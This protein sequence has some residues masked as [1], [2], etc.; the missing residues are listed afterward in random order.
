MNEIDI[1][2][3]A[4]NNEKTIKQSLQKI[5]SYAPPR[6]LIVIDGVSKDRTLEI[7]T[8]MGA[9][10]HSDKGRGLGYARNMALT[11]AQTSI[12]GFVDA[13]SYVPS[14]FFDLLDHFKDPFVAAASASTIYGYGNPPLQKFHEWMLQRGGQDVGFVGTLV[15]RRTLLDV[16]GI[17][18]DLQAYED[19]ELYSRLKMHGQSWI[20]D[21][22]VVMLHPQSMLAFLSHAR[23]WGR[24]ARRSGLKPYPFVASLLTSPL[25][26]LKLAVNVHPM[27]AFYYPLLRLAYLLG[28]VRG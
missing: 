13:D 12:V 22:Q 16:G 5:L 4:K 28:Y 24:G 21:K 8:A 11:L 15:R 1:V 10:I 19:W 26:G 25:W 27:H 18:K 3:C 9:E 23:S 14:N 7:A 6:R 17:R 2:V 20:S